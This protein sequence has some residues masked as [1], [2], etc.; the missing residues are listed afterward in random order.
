MILQTKTKYEA[1]STDCSTVIPHYLGQ[2]KGFQLKE[3]LSVSSKQPNQQNLLSPA[4]ESQWKQVVLLQPFASP[5]W[6]PTS[7]K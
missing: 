1:T 6:V 2:M 4:N 7:K 5:H 3:Q